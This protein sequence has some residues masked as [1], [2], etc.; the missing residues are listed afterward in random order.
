MNDLV[1]THNGVSVTTH[2]KVS[3]YTDNNEQSIQRLIR[4]HKADLEEFGI[5]NFENI[6]TQA[7]QGYTHKKLYYL[8]EQQ[9]TLLL[10]YLRNTPVV[11]EFKKALVR[12]FYKLRTYA[13]CD[14]QQQRAIEKTHSS[15]VRQG[16]K[17]QIAFKNKQIKKL[18]TKLAEQTNL[19]ANDEIVLYLNAIQKELEANFHEIYSKLGAVMSFANSKERFFLDT[20]FTKDNKC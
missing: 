16:Y 14:L 19:K 17:M 5:I 20:H 15:Q 6:Q 11:R 9:A 18:K 8:N 7:G 3:V 1:I 10:T 13:L 4:T 12:E 2:N